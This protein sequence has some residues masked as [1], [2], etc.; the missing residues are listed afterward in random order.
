VAIDFD[1][2]VDADQALRAFDFLADDGPRVVFNTQRSLADDAR[3]RAQS[4][5]PGGLKRGWRTVVIADPSTDD[6]FGLGVFT[7]DQ[8][9]YERRYARS[10]GLESRDGD[11]M[12]RVARWANFGTGDKADGRK[13]KNANRA[14][15]GQRAQRFLRPVSRAVQ[16]REAQEDLL[17]VARRRGFVEGGRL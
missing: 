7:P 16:R 3:R 6:T 5:A 9:M 1:T 14:H 2:K 13:I 10:R 8:T 17:R 11:G 15:H 12:L 4:N